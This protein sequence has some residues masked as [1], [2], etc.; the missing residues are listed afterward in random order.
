M[1]A[2]IRKGKLILNLILISIAAIIGIAVILTI[3]SS[4]EITNTYNDMIEEE[5]KIKHLEFVLV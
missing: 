3:I 4:V 2:K 5:L 1:E